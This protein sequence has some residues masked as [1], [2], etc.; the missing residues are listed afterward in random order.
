MRLTQD[1]K[2]EY[3]NELKGAKAAA[4]KILE[5]PAAKP[6]EKALTKYRAEFEEL[7]T[8]VLLS[9]KPGSAKSLVESFAKE[10]KDP[11]IARE[12]RN[13]FASVITPII[14]TAGSEAP[15]IKNALSKVYSHLN[16][17]FMT[18][19]QKEAYSTI[20]TVDSMINLKVYSPAV[21]DS[22]DQ[23]LGRGTSQQMSNPDEFFEKKAAE[24]N[25]EQ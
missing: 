8:K 4:E 22:V 6:D 10:I 14:S 15:A 13:E 9:L 19:A 5:A 25:P 2:K 7:K 12:F 20:E 24:E 21:S 17:G 3:Q 23:Y 18:E 11:Y 1:I 16:D